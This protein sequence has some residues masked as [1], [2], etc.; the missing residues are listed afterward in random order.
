MKIKVYHGSTAIVQQPL[1]LVGR[2]NLD[3]GQGFYLTA[4]REQAISWAS[5]IVNRGR[6]QWLNVYELDIEQVKQAYHS[7]SFTAYD[8]EWLN[9]II[10]SRKGFE[11]WRGYDFIEGGI[12]DDRVIIAVEMY[13]RN[14][15]RAEE[16][17]KMLA[18]HKP[19]NQ[20]CLLSQQLIDEN[21]H[22]VCAEPLN[23]EAG[24]PAEKKGGYHVK[25]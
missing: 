18:Y 17:L 14:E 2:H 8:Q 16:A 10:Q 5:R 15:I 11:P 19:N 23:D 7:L 3:F 20:I 13:F 1:A 9:F 12:A 24:H 4:L 25:P 21:L 6:P 22:F